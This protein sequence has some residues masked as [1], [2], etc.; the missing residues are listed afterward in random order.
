ML[1][2]YQRVISLKSLVPISDEGEIT[3]RDN[4]K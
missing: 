4:R 2:L 3:F 1:V